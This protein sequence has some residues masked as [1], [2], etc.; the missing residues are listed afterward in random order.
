[1]PTQP[2]SAPTLDMRRRPFR[3]E[4]RAFPSVPGC[5]AS[6]RASPSRVSALSGYPIGGAP[7]G[8]AAFRP[9]GAESASPRR[10]VRPTLGLARTPTSRPR[11]SAA[12]PSRSRLPRLQQGHH[13]HGSPLHPAGHRAYHP[14]QATRG[15]AP[16]T[17]KTDPLVGRGPERG[18][19]TLCGAPT[20]IRHEDAS[21]K[22]FHA[23]IS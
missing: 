2:S 16:G 4:G 13:L 12:R 22:V 11:R 6:H 7:C 17:R 15:T 20:H 5:R 14:C 8:P 1:M 19:L 9:L 21:A 23:C 18:L 10:S 3:V